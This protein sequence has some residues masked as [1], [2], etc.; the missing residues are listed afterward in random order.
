MRGFDIFMRAA[1]LICDRDPNV[2][3]LVAGTDRIAYGGDEQYT[4]GKTFKEWTLAQQEYDLNRIRFLG[5]IDPFELARMLA[6]TTCT[7][8]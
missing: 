2:I 3:V 5:R 7:S 4:G 6:A 8:T 1:K